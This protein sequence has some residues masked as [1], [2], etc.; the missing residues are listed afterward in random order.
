MKFRDVR[1]GFCNSEVLP[2]VFAWYPP[3]LRGRQTSTKDTYDLLQI[4]RSLTAISSFS[5]QWQFFSDAL[6]LSADSRETGIIITLQ[7][8]SWT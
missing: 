6:T 7:V 8:S 1:F 5:L 2:K 4:I 3:K